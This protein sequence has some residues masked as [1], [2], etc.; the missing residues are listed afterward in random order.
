M[1]GYYVKGLGS[2]GKRRVRCLLALGAKPEQIWGNDIREDRRKEAKDKYG[3]N[4]VK[5]ESELD[6]NKIDAIVVSLPPD[7]HKIGT[8][9]AVKYNKPVFVEASVVL[10]EVK[11]IMDNTKNIFVAPS[12]TFIFHPMIKEVKKIVESGKFGKVCNFTY[13]SGQYLP[14]WHPWENVNDFYVSN[15]ETGGAREIVPYELT[16][17]TDVFGF[18]KEIK[19]YFRKTGEIGCDIEDSYVSTLD[20][21]NMLGGLLVDVMSRYPARNLII[22]FQDGQIQWKWDDEKLSVFDAKTGNTEYIKQQKQPH[23]EGYADMIGE[24]MYI[25]EIAAFLD[26]IN[27]NK[28][29][30][31][32]LQ[33][34]AAVLKLLN[35]LEESDGGF[36][37]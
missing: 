15:R 34:D 18:P 22:N 32:T 4:I 27:D 13:H 5:D 31:N 1:S 26:G 36:Y 14:D 30:P 33:K 3:I 6:F 19:G 35:S 37:K 8:D 16:W 9:I 10:S 20:Y 23:E 29:Y 12:C 28:K 11:A 7:R 17:I 24:Q 25:D 2:M 21:G